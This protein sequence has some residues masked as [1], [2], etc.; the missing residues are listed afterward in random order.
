MTN[1]SLRPTQT[2]WPAVSVFVAMSLAWS[3]HASNFVRVP[4][5]HEVSIEVPENWV[6]GSGSLRKTIDAAVE[7]GG[8]LAKDSS[9]HGAGVR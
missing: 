5:G 7:A 3:C 8:H 6:V 2:M 1:V 9:I 4:I